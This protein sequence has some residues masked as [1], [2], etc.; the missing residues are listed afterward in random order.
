MLELALPLIEE[1]KKTRDIFL[2]LRNCG[3]T[4]VPGE[5]GEL[6]WLE[7][8]S[9]SNSDILPLS[10]EWLYGSRRE[11]QN[12]GPANHIRRLTSS[13]TGLPGVIKFFP[14]GVGTNPFPV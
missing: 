11:T 4:E 8:L 7:E 6:V 12:V 2:D 3:L 9:L 10:N 14:S 1:N 5:I 13:M